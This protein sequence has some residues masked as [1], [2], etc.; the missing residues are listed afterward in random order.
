MITTDKNAAVSEFDIVVRVGK[1]PTQGKKLVIQKGSTI[2]SVSAEDVQD[3]LNAIYATSNVQ[4]ETKYVAMFD[5]Y[6]QFNSVV[7]ADGANDYCDTCP[8][9]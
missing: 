7:M 6:K 1:F 2:I 4:C 5:D 9:R 3:F 8:A